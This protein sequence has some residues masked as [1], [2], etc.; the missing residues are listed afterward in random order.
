VLKYN[1]KSKENDEVTL[2]VEVQNTE[3][4]EELKKTFN[5]ISYKVKIPGFRKGKIPRNI[6][7]M[8]FGKEY[9]FEK[10]AEE[11]IEKTYYDA[12]LQSKIEPIDRPNIKIIQIEEEKPLIYEVKVKVKPEVKIGSLDEIEVKKEKVN[13]LEKDVDAEISRMQE[14]QAKFNLVEGRKAKAGDFLVVDS[15]SFTEGKPLENSKMSK[16]LIELGK[17]MTPEISKQ[18]IGSSAGEEKDVII[19]V[20][21]DSKEKEMAGKEIVHKIKVLEIKEKELPEINDELAQKLGDFKDLNEFKDSVKNNLEKRAEN[22]SKNNFEKDLLNKVTDACEVNIPDILIN[23]EIDFMIKSL[24]DD[25]KRSNATLDD[26]LKSIKTDESKL[27]E[28]YKMVAERRVKQELIVDKIA[29]IQDISANDEEV[30]EKI[31]EIAKDIKQ[32]PIKVEATFKKNNNIEGIKETIKREKIFNYLSK[33][34]NK[35]NKVKKNTKKTD[36]KT[37]TSK[38]EE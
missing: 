31:V 28:E 2:E 16:Q 36:V 10:T 17:S 12:I 6:L 22:I 8:H 24:E 37:E 7:E 20:P 5:D 35:K 9:F 33:Q 30:K 27:R 18:L 38:K 14:G 23:R 3:V 25:L 11:L 15:E 19:K 4:K 21:D 34:I 13:I 29:K 32:D 1:I 26:Y